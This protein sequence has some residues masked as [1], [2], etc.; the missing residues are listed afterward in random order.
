V[1]TIWRDFEAYLLQRS[2]TS[3]QAQKVQQL[4]LD[5]LGEPHRGIED[6][7]K[8]ADLSTLDGVM[9]LLVLY[10]RALTGN[11]AIK[12]A[13]EAARWISSSYFAAHG[14]LP[15]TLSSFASP[16]ELEPDPDHPADEAAQA[17]WADELVRIG[18]TRWRPRHGH[19]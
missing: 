16:L 12:I 6:T 19:I 8:A 2:P 7:R 1:W 4:L 13:R 11:L 5:R 18:W 9:S 10:D 15:P 3:E 17:I 14:L